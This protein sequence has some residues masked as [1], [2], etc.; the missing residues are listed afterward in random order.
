M[1]IEIDNI[2]K[3]TGG[4]HIESGILIFNQKHPD[5]KRFNDYF[6]KCY[7]DDIIHQIKYPLDTYLMYKTLTDLKISYNDLNKDR[8]LKMRYITSDPNMTFLHPEIK[9]RFS[10]LIGA[11]KDK[12]K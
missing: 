6:K 11:S 9:P 8:P 7:T 12:I 2:R 10:H 3:G 1:Q 4:F 5:R